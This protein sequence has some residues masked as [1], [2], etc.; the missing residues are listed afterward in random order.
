[1]RRGLL[2]VQDQILM[3]AKPQTLVKRAE[4]ITF[5]IIKFTHFKTMTEMFVSVREEPESRIGAQRE[6]GK[7][8]VVIEVD[9]GDAIRQDVDDPHGHDSSV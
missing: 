4:H 1:M 5:C 7:V 8:R 9:R 2:A 6:E 3:S